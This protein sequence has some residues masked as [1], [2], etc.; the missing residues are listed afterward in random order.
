ME[1]PGR[2]I[3]NRELPMQEAVSLFLL[4]KVEEFAKL[5][6]ARNTVLFT[7]SNFGKENMSH[8][9]AGL[10]TGSMDLQNFIV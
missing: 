1:L 2:S 9:V 3:I 5:W 6:K 8:L 4:F 7:G 10:V